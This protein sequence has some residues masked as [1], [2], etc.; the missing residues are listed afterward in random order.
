VDDFSTPPHTGPF[1]RAIKGFRPTDIPDGLSTT[2][3]V[4]DRSSKLS[5]STWAGGPTGALNPFLMAPGN[6]GAEITLVMYHA[7]PTGPN[8]PG[9][10][11]ADSTWSPHRTGVPAVFGDGSVRYIANSIDINVWMAIAT[12]AGGEPVSGND[13]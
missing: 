4:A 1:M 9:V 7:G 10:F 13:Y 11:D 6:Y 2:M 8:T 3:F 5:Y 12:R